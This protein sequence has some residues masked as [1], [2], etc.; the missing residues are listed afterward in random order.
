VDEQRL[1]LADGTAVRIRSEDATV[2]RTSA[3]SW[4]AERLCHAAPHRPDLIEVAFGLPDADGTPPVA[5]T[6]AWNHAPAQP[7]IA[8]PRTVA[9]QPPGLVLPIQRPGAAPPGLS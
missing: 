4:L 8:P 2:D 6:L 3:G 9:D 7:A 5:V 1:R